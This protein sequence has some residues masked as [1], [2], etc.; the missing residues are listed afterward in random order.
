MGFSYGYSCS[1]RA[2]GTS[3]WR[4]GVG[5]YYMRD[6]RRDHYVP[7]DRDDYIYHTRRLVLGPSKCTVGF[8]YLFLTS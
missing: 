3:A 4:P 8:F 6:T 7:D 1:L 2:G 5:L